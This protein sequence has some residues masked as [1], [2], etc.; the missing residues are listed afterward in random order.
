[1]IEDKY[2]IF[3]KNLFLFLF[4]IILGVTTCEIA[5]RLIGLGDPILYDADPLIGYRLKPNQRKKD[6]KIPTLQ[7][8]M[9][10]SG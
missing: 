3:F 6:L 2:K 10:V 8:T 5:A 9:K 7:A 1:M 4:S